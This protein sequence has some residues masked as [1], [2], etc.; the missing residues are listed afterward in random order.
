MARINITKDVENHTPGTTWNLE[1]EDL[2]EICYSKCFF[3]GKKENVF[4]LELYPK[5]EGSASLSLWQA[6]GDALSTFYLLIV[7]QYT[8]TVKLFLHNNNNSNKSAKQSPKAEN[9]N[10]LYDLRTIKTSGL[11]EI[12]CL[13]LHV[14]EINQTACEI[15]KIVLLLI[16]IFFPF[17]FNMRRNAL[18]IIYLK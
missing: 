13:V 16:V 11:K 1:N 15:G 5:K 6:N 17:L 3:V 10:G 18:M 7:L 12:G 2:S 14:E 8:N 9:I 4:Y